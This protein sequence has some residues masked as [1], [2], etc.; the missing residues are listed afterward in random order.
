MVVGPNGGGPEGRDYL[1]P[2]GAADDWTVPQAWERFT[3]LEHR[4]WDRLYAR[5][6][7]MLRGRAVE[8]YHRSLDILKLSRPGIPD[9][10]ELNERLHAVTGWT[11]VAVPSRVPNHIFHGHL[12]ERRFPAGNFIRSPDQLGYLREPDVFHDVFGHVPLLAQPDWADFIQEMGKLGLK[13][14]EAGTISRLA[15]LYWY[16][17][18]FGLCREHGQLRI[19][20]AG[21][22]SS[23]D[24]SIHALE[25]PHARRLEFDLRRLLRTRYRIN[26]FQQV[27]FVIDHFKDLLDVIRNAD[28]PGLLAEMED[29]N[30]FE[31]LEMLPG[32][33]PVVALAT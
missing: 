6:S 25:S 7:E 3:A 5:Q 31:P 4:T 17:V 30:D 13:A 21:I 18:E 16:T 27:Y 19:Y 23:Y 26:H 20:G 8:A 28:V 22:V 11:V 2:A 15:Q 14:C 9:F 33:R 29:E 1:P 12:A 32:D 24:E 10:D